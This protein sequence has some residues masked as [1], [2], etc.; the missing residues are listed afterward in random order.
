MKSTGCLAGFL[1]IAFGVSWTCWLPAAFA[2]AGLADSWARWLT[3]AGALGPAAAGIALTYRGNDP[4]DQHDYWARAVDF[5][6]IRGRWFIPILLLYPLAT[7]AAL[8]FDTAVTAVGPDLEMAKRLLSAPW[9]GIVF[10]I[11]VLLLGPLPE[12][13]GWRGY[14]L[15]RL[16]RH[17]SP[18][19]SSII[20]GLVWALWHLP[21]FFVR[22]SYQHNLDFGSVSFWCYGVTIVELSV[23]FTWIYNNNGRSTLAAILFHFVLNLTGSLARG[24]PVS[25][26]ARAVILGIVAAIV[27][28]TWRDA[29]VILRPDRA[30][31]ESGSS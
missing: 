2:E 15:D 17:W 14:A 29:K 31:A 21:L 30:E 26:A 8:L 6:R 18:I 3:Y 20:L 24:S 9:S 1:A 11:W 12:E 7:L 10:A 22:G 27:V 4:Q 13:L 25:E 16:Q 19:M 28:L 5:S 23:L